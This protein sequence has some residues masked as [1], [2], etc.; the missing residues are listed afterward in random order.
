MTA[1]AVTIIP[2]TDGSL[3][4]HVTGDVG[5]AWELFVSEASLRSSAGFQSIGS[6]IGTGKHIIVPSPSLS[7]GGYFGYL[8]SATEVSKVVYFAAA[9]AAQDIWYLAM[10]SIAARITALGLAAVDSRR[11]EVRKIPVDNYL[12]KILLNAMKQGKRDGSPAIIISPVVET[13]NSSSQSNRSIRTRYGCRVSMFRGNS[14]E[15]IADHESQ[16]GWR[17]KITKEFDH[18]PFPGVPGVFHSTVEPGQVFPLEAWLKQ[19]DVQSVVIRCEACEER[20]N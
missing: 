17:T 16:L 20:T 8:A 3:D 18:Q 13:R 11:I 10:V 15:P 1:L 2:N 19:Y 7:Q 14:G 6:G 12:E 9:N 5:V 4:V